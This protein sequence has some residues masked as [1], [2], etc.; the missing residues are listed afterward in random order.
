MLAAITP[1]TKWIII[2]NVV[3][4]LLTYLLLPN[5]MYHLA[6]YFPLSPSFKIWQVV[7]HMFVHGGW[8]HL[9]FNMFTLYSFGPVLE[10]VLGDRKYLSF[11]LVCGLG[12]F[13]LYNLW[14]YFQVQADANTLANMGINPAPIISRADFFHFDEAYY[15]GL[16]PE[17]QSLF[18]TVANP[19][20]GASGAIFGVL[21]AFAILF[22]NAELMIMFIP[23]PIKAKYLLPVVI[24]GSIFLGLKQL[25]GDN[26][27]HFAH[28]GGALIG[29][30][31]IRGWKHKHHQL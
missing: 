24:L 4:F 20:V 23:I 12:S 5:L 8:M 2:I 9:F 17:G 14:I 19:M 18:R 7:T 15:N 30:L 1:V 26:I 3:V 28:L 21:T 6:A 13:L 22:P 25:E 31:W 29:Y 11:Y 16:T 27:A 10:K